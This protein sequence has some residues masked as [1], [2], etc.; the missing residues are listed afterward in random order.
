MLCSYGCEQEGKHHFKRVNKYCCSDHYT[1]CPAIKNKMTGKKHTTETKKKI[2]LKHKGKI[3]TE[4]TK[5]K[6]SIA[7]KGKTLSSD[8]IEKVR[9]TLVGRKCSE[10]TK[11]KIKKSNLGKK[12]SKETRKK[13]KLAA[14]GNN[15]MQGK[16]HTEETKKNLSNINKKGIEYW[17]KT[18]PLFSQIEEMRYNPDKKEIQV[19]CKNHNCPN[20]KEK[21]GWFTPTYIQL[22]SRITQ[23]E[24]NGLDNCYF[25][26]SDVCK[27][28][29]PLYGLRSDPFKSMDKPYTESEYQTFREH[30]LERDNCN[31]QYCGKKADHVH[32]ERPQKLEPFFTLDPDYAWSVCK[33]CHYEKGHKDECSTGKIANQNCERI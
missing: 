10:E 23:I 25:Y 14:L 29:C 20:S 26:C 9:K 5:E 17:R 19:H 16:T 22:N 13:N 7:K 28:E 2:G 18:Y 6:I 31:C 1:K 4:E 15:N 24:K 32:H 27:N 33:S 8:H 21:E 11:L 30:V 3:L 12:R